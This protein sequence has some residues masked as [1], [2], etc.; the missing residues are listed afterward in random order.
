MRSAL[1]QV[2][3]EAPWEPAAIR[4]L[5][6]ANQE[7]A[8][9]VGMR[10]EDAWTL[11]F[12][13]DEL[14]SNVVDH[15]GATWLEYRLEPGGRSPRMVIRD[16][17][18]AFDPTDPLQVEPTSDRGLGLTM[19]MAMIRLMRYRR[20]GDVNEVTVEIQLKEDQP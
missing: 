9:V 16:N 2:K 7:I 14:A 5:R 3:I 10:Q 11:I 4:A 8:E 1:Y 6:A 17:G 13:A 12:V 19:L 15:A 18:E 20:D